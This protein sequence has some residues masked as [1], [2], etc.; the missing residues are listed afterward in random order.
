MGVSCSRNSR[1]KRLVFRNN[2]LRETQ[3][4]WYKKIGCF[5]ASL[6][7]FF[8]KPESQIPIQH[9]FM[10]FSLYFSW[11]CCSKSLRN[12][13]LLLPLHWIQKTFFKFIR[14]SAEINTRLNCVLQPKTIHYS[15]NSSKFSS[16]LHIICFS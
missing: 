11:I 1:Q 14:Y 5:V 8:V 2:K 7:F 15:F 12:L 6:C 16:V 4:K 13:S 10:H 3:A 9:C